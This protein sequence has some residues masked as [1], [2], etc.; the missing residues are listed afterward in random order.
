MFSNNS[1]DLSNINSFWT[2]YIDNLRKCGIR[3]KD[4]RWHV[5][6]AEEYIKLNSGK[7]IRDFNR[8]EVEDYFDK[9]LR[10]K[11]TQDWQ[12][13]QTVDA[14]QN[15]FITV[16]S[17]LTNE[18]DW[19]LWRAKAETLVEQSTISYEEIGELPSQ[20]VYPLGSVSEKMKD[21]HG[22][23]LDALVIE[24]RSRNYSIRTEQAYLGWAKKFLLFLGDKDPKIEGTKEITVFLQNLAVYKHV[25]ASTQNQALN[26]L[27]FFYEKALKIPV[28][29]LGNFARAKRPKRLP[30]VL[31][32]RE[33]SLLLK[34]LSGIHY[35]MGS[36]LYG[37][38][39]RLMECVRLRIQ[40]IDFDR[41]LIVV[42]DGKG[43]KDRVVPFPEIL[44]EH[45]R[46]HL[47]HVKEI[48]KQDL[49]DG[50]GNVYLPDALAT[51]YPNAMKEWGWQYV[52]PSK[53]LSVDPRSKKTRRHH[54]HENSLQKVIKKASLKLEI[55]KKVNCHALRHSFATHLL[56]SGQDIR[57]IQELLGHSDV[58][59]TMI[60]THV[61]NRGGTG[62]ISPLD[63]L[64]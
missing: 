26:A 2:N 37:A 15:L 21:L 60:Y 10:T 53:R 28:G 64:F 25:A 63:S 40:D 12:Y 59:T 48:H 4:L 22:E 36:L 9:L 54:I 29:E 58:S 17:P 43:K 46:V 16:N 1:R 55:P 13:T 19:R 34:N 8:I 61:L 50:F 5:K 27:V 56:E 33:V 23:L 57:T 7:K 20:K 32:Q 18:V 31:S 14:I 11:R 41:K 49:D 51:K 45:L 6:R 47:I 39:M 44:R 38:G 24:V 42:R 52:F 30:T 35:M 62:V 3:Q